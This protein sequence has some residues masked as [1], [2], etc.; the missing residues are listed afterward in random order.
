MAW[1][2]RTWTLMFW[3]PAVVS[4]VLGVYAL[5]NGTLVRPAPPAL[6]FLASLL[7]QFTS[8]PLSI[9]WT[10]GLVAQSALAIY[11]SIRLKLEA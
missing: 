1:L 11:V 4:A 2:F 10:A 9:A 5:G 8:E 3:I 7:L 6:W